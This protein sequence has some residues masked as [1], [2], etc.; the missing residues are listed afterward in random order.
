MVQKSQY[1]EPTYCD[2][3]FI[4]KHGVLCQ[5]EA[6][7]NE[8]FSPDFCVLVVC[9]DIFHFVRNKQFPCARSHSD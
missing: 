6:T 1:V 2:F 8:V 5:M 3:V 9:A 7:W 4:K